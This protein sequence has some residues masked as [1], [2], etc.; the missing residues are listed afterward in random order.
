MSHNSKYLPFP[1]KPT[2]K[3]R[4][5]E[6]CKKKKK[7]ISSCESLLLLLHASSPNARKY[8]PLPKLMKGFFHYI[9]TAS[10]AST[11]WGEM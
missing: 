9:P 10:C 5:Q 11:F 8:D 4:D 3:N 1:C 7:A 6:K 2:Q